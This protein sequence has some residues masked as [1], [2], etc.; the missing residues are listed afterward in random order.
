MGD[1]RGVGGSAYF[2]N[3]DASRRAGPS[4]SVPSQKR[5]KDILPYQ[6]RKDPDSELEIQGE[7]N[8]FERIT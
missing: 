3:S 8:S 1:E 2:S 4:S 7:M 6:A 5:N